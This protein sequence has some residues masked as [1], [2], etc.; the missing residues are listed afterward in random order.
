MS[1]A[2][3]KKNPMPGKKAFSF[4]HQAMGTFFEV[5][6]A[7]K[8]ER[9]SQDAARAFFREVDRLEGFFSRFDDRSEISRINRLKL[10]DM[11]PIGLETYECLKLSF[12]LMVETGGA[13]NINFRA[14]KN[15]AEA[16]QSREASNMEKVYE[17]QV[18]M[19]ASAARAKK[20][21]GEIKKEREYKKDKQKKE[22]DKSQKEP[23]SAVMR[24]FPSDTEHK[25]EASL[26][27][28]LAGVDERSELEAYLQFFPLELM[29]QGGGYRVIRLNVPGAGLD[30]D[31][32]AIGKGYALERAA[33]IFADW[34]ISDFLVN[35]GRSTVYARGAK[36]WPVAVGGGFDFL[37]PGKIHLLNRALSGSGHEVKG[38][39]IFDPRHRQDR[40]RHLAVWVSHPSPAV[41]DGLSTAFMVMSLNEI[42]RY[43]EVRPEVWTLIISRDKKS[44]LFNQM[45][46]Y[47]PGG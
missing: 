33:Q 40:S 42:R 12:Q 23:D 34:E 45:G 47:E 24:N 28:G 20:L 18:E 2:R 27:P 46:F 8:S 13:F 39:H 38:E 16:A 41:A 4:S 19:K 5:F 22:I 37:K 21:E 32:G 3:E 6:I 35:A 25:P 17:I 10:G 7:G 1:R 30:L 31:L 44:Y 29:E 43:C 14:I 15:W 9:Y 26:S 36:P 11:L